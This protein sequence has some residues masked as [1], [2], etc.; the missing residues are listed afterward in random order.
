MRLQAR[1]AV[2]DHLD[3]WIYRVQKLYRV[4]GLRLSAVPLAHHLKP[5][6][7]HERPVLNHHLCLIFFASE[8][9]VFPQHSSGDYSLLKL[10]ER[11]DRPASFY[12]VFYR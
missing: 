10:Q 2:F 3:L 6:I 5:R 12:A 4:F 8:L 11:R 9:L 7:P 1:E